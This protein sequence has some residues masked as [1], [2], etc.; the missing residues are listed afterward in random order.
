MLC[1]ND[2]TLVTGRGEGAVGSLALSGMP[3]LGA[4]PWA[5]GKEAAHRPVSADTLT[6]VYGF[7]VLAFHFF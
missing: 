7:L 2:I 6:D 1:F 5:A 3:C 4:Y